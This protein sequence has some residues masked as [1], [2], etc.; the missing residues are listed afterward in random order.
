MHQTT[1]RVMRYQANLRQEQ[2][3]APRMKEV[4]V[5][6]ETGLPL[7]PAEPEMGEDGQPILDTITVDLLAFADQD[8]PAEWLFYADPAFRVELIRICSQGLDEAQKQ[9]AMGHL[10]GGIVL[11]NAA[12]LPRPPLNREERRR[13]ERQRR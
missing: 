10:T 11:A 4:E 9:Q 8:Q 13:A 12:D 6:D 5:D 2:A 1:T 7:G 3:Q